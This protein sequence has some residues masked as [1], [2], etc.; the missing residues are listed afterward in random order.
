MSSEAGTASA[1]ST[2]DSPGLHGVPN[3][4][5]APADLAAPPAV[6]IVTTVRHGGATLQRTASSL[7]GQSFQAWEWLLILERAPDPGAQIILDQYRQGDPRVRVLDLPQGGG[8]GARAAISAAA[9]GAYV[10]QLDEGAEIEPTALEELYW[11]FETHVEHADDGC[12]APAG[13]HAK[14][15]SAG[16]PAGCHAQ[17]PSAG[18]PAPSAG[19]P[20]AMTSAPPKRWYSLKGLPEGPGAPEPFG[21]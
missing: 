20:G 12:H 19:P 6:S 11:F 13:C 8:T 4:G 18:R 15:P 21:A 10:W 16:M 3:F 7:F 2:R 14:A 17:A 5:Y 1:G 9:R